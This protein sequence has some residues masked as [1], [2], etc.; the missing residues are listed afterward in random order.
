MLSQNPNS[1]PPS[2]LALAGSLWDCI[3]GTKEHIAITV[4]SRHTCAHFTSDKKV[5]LSH[6]LNAQSEPSGL[7]SLSRARNEAGCFRGNL[8][9]PRR[10]IRLGVKREQRSLSRVLLCAVSLTQVDLGGE[11]HDPPAGESAEGQWSPRTTS[12]ACV[13]PMASSPHGGIWSSPIS[14]A[15]GVQGR[16]R[17]HI[18]ITC[19]TG[20]SL[21]SFY[22]ICSYVYSPLV[23]NLELKLYPGNVCV[24]KT[25]VCRG[26][27]ATH[28]FRAARVLGRTPE[29]KGCLLY[30]LSSGGGGAVNYSSKDTGRGHHGGSVSS[31]SDPCF[32][33]RL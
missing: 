7:P 9:P 19:I 15:R 16:E 28:G 31:A 17:A 3:T 10:L 33:L 29:D 1:K 13:P 22:F 24:G 27:S 11:A 25:M 12:R 30:A 6:T 32:H 5:L 21:S 4:H 14:Q 26:F 20:I 8:Q 18:H 23:P 2:L